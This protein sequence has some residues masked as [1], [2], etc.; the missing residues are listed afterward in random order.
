MV[1]A[2][3]FAAFCPCPPCP[4]CP[5]CAVAIAE[6][7]RRDRGDREDS[8]QSRPICPFC[9]SFLQRQ[10][11]RHPTPRAVL[12][13]REGERPPV[14]LGDLPAQDQANTGTPGL[15]RVERHEEIGG[16]GDAW[17]VV[18]DLEFK[19]GRMSPSMPTATNSTNS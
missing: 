7:N 10:R 16:L 5:S 1:R 4:P 6:A 17:S 19:L 11:H 14:R 3:K 9:P 18:L 12:P 13:V 2:A 15:G 8:D